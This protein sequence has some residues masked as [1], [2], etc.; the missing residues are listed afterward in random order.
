MQSTR[1]KNIAI[2]AAGIGLAALAVVALV[3]DWGREDAT[4]PDVAADSDG[5]AATSAD[6]SGTSEIGKHPVSAGLAESGIAFSG[7]ELSE[8]SP[9]PYERTPD[10]LLDLASEERIYDENGRLL[11]PW[12]DLDR[13][14]SHPVDLSWFILGALESYIASDDQQYLDAAEINAQALLDSGEL[15]NGALW[16]P[17]DFD[18]VMHGQY[19]LSA[20]WYAG[21]AQGM[22]LSVFTRMYEVTG[23]EKWAHAA[24]E[25]FASFTQDAPEDRMFLVPDEDSN[26][27]FEEYVHPGYPESRVVNGHM[28]AMWGLRD[29]ALEFDSEE[30]ELLFDAG[31]TTMANTFDQWRVEDG[32]SFYCAGPICTENAWQPANYHRGV[33]YQLQ[34]LALMTGDR[35]FL[36]MA[37]TMQDDSIAAA[38][39]S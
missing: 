9:R 1:I 20:P 18:Y 38:K 16:F 10:S 28:Y 37:S 31:A 24:H 29:Y 6:P 32:I 25:V 34:E 19:Q 12:P 33:I 5:S 13:Y 15:L 36:E 11:K 3:F 8:M 2:L 17:Y 39:T 26:L 35:T 30:A 4:E 22:A 27:W 23:E 7:Y 21:M 14:V